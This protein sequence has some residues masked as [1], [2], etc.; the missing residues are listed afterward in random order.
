M[1]YRTVLPKH[2]CAC[3]PSM[4][5]VQ[6]GLWLCRSGTGPESLHFQHIPRWC[7]HWGPWTTPWIS[8]LS[9]VT[10]VLS[11]SFAAPWTVARQAPLSMELSRQEYW[12][13]LPF[14]SPEG[15]PNPGIEPAT[16]ASKVDSL[17]LSHQGNPY[18]LYRKGINLPLLGTFPAL[19]KKILDY[20]H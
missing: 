10:S 2:W 13:G 3:K 6:G 12:G 8:L 19:L 20:L 1:W 18:M 11:D 5:L 7:W 9:L 17:S 15:C 4:D 16:A 14:P